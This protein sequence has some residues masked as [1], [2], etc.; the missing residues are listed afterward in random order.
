MSCDRRSSSRWTRATAW[1]FGQSRSR[2]IIADAPVI[3]S[4]ATL[5]VTAKR[6]GST[7]RDRTHDATLCGAKRRTV[8]LSIDVAVAAEHVRQP[9]RATD[10]SSV[11]SGCAGGGF[12]MTARDAGVDPADWTSRRPRLSR[13]PD[14][15][16]WWPG[17]D[18]RAATGSSASR[19]RI[20]ENGQRKRNADS[21][22][23]RVWTRRTAGGPFGR[24]LRRRLSRWIARF[25][26]RR[27]IESSTVHAQNIEQFRRERDIAVLAAFALLGASDHPPAI[28]GGPSNEGLPESASPRRSRRP[29][30]RDAGD[31]R[32][33]RGNARPL[34]GSRQ[35]TAFEASWEEGGPR[36]SFTAG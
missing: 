32:H 18:D 30:S 5:D 13:C 4:I 2:R 26:R 25:G 22:V 16:R 12:G 35:Q 24:R 31:T 19:C 15:W 34:Q 1:H 10:R 14:T 21:A 9:E 29:R 36:Q 6:R 11:Q 28:D 17:S 33:S 8:P 3:A 23:S 20:P 27:T 7:Q